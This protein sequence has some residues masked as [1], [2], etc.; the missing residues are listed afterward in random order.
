MW[1]KSCDASLVVKDYWNSNKEYTAS[2]ICLQE[3]ATLYQC[4][5]EVQFCI[6]LNKTQSSGWAMK[7]FILRLFPLIWSAIDILDLDGSSYY[8]IIIIKLWYDHDITVHII[9][10]VKQKKSTLLSDNGPKTQKRPNLC[11]TL[12][13]SMGFKDSKYDVQSVILVI[14]RSSDYHM[15]I[16]IL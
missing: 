11:F 10:K 7:F 1:E 4:D 2:L 6:K 14:W 13:K 16:I 15:V 8:H 3:T 5:G 12:K 9:A